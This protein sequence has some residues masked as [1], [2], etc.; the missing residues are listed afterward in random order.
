MTHLIDLSLRRLLDRLPSL[1]RGGTTSPV[2]AAAACS[3]SS[4]TF[5]FSSV[6]DGYMRQAQGFLLVFTSLTSFNSLLLA[7]NP[8]L[9]LFAAARLHLTLSFHSLLLVFSFK[10]LSSL[11]ALQGHDLPCPRCWWA[12]SVTWM[13]E[14]RRVTRQSALQVGSQWGHVPYYETS[15]S[16]FSSATSWLSRRRGWP[17]HRHFR[18]AAKRTEIQTSG[19]VEAFAC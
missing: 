16:V 13:E 5:G 4:R 18:H 19:G 3:H 11:A 14:D 1:R 8:P 7:F 15:S 9:F 10:S 12:T 6:R 17:N 2:C